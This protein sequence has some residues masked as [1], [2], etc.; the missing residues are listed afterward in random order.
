MG[1]VVLGR[2]YQEMSISLKRQNVNNSPHPRPGKS[3]LLML[4]P[5]LIK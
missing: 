2:Q 1:T 5:R 4:W 3:T